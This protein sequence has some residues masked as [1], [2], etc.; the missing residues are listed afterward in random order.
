[1]KKVVF[2]L[3]PTAVGKTFFGV[4]LA[5]SLGGEIIS[6]DSVQI[7]KQ[8]DIGSAK[9]TK[10][11]M[12][13]VPHFGIDILQPHEEFSAYDFV[14]FTREKIEEISARG[15]LPIVVGG[16]GLYVK[17]LIGGYDFANVEKN[18]E[19]RQQ[20]EE[21][22]KTTGNEGLMQILREKAPSVA[23]KIDCHNTVRLIRAAEIALSGG[24]K[25][26]SEVDIDPIVF[27]LF[28][29]RE[30]LY[31]SINKRVDIMLANGLVGEVESLKKQGLTRENQSMRAIG[32]KEVLSYLDGEIDY[33]RMVELIKQHSRNY[34]KRQL[35]FLRGM[36]NVN[37][38]DVENKQQALK[39]MLEKICCWKD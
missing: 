34:A 24:E 31:E 28:R 13:G 36:E 11:E 12:Q 25:N 16:T 2:I 17:A 21:I 15:H 37:V 20:L 38:V 14:Q 6:C 30:K 22:Y 1:M 7:Y 3:G 23:E 19:L 10:E 33:Q 9:V 18:E 4:E 26:R 35:T 5:K 8:L 29:D 27:A 32:Y 39:Q